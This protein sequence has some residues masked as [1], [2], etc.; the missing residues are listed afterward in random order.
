MK[1]EYEEFVQKAM[2]EF[3][4]DDK[5]KDKFKSLGEDIADLKEIIMLKIQDEISIYNSTNKD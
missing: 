4:G 3:G 2:E 5:F 1:P